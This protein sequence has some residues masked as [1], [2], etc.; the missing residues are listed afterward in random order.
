MPSSPATIK[1]G[2]SCEKNA[3]IKGSKAAFGMPA[4]LRI[5]CQLAALLRR[6][7]ALEPLPLPKGFPQETGVPLKKTS[8]V[9]AQL[10]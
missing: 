8:C 7:R 2:A 6:S 9:T 10:C 4:L 5:P 1:K 3:W